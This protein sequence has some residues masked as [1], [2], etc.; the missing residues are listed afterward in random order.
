[1]TEKPNVLEIGRTYLYIGDFHMKYNNLE[2]NDMIMKLIKMARVEID[3]GSAY[4]KPYYACNFS[5]RSI[6][7]GMANI[8]DGDIN[9]EKQYMSLNTTPLG[10]S[11]LVPLDDYGKHTALKMIRAIA[12]KS[13]KTAK[14]ES[15]REHICNNAKA[16]LDIIKNEK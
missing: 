15:V 10:D 9:Q 11:A 2:T 7:G 13:F 14:A 8:Y 1:M 16:Y 6:G 3:D 4:F 5:F 12:Y